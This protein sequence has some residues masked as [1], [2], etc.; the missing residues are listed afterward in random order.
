MRAYEIMSREVITVGVDASIVDAINIMLAHHI[1]G[2]PVVD[3]AGKL[4]G[5]LP[6]GDFI[7]RAELGTQRKLGRWLT[8][9][10]GAIR[11]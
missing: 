3:P 2:L 9:L 6:E 8:L 1:S 11:A 5:I 4:V 10:A 7:R